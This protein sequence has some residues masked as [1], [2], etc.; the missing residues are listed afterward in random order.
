[1]TDQLRH[2][3]PVHCAEYNQRQRAAHNCFCRPD[4]RREEAPA[5]AL[6]ELVD[7]D[8]GAEPESLCDLAKACVNR[9]ARPTLA[10]GNKKLDAE[11]HAAEGQTS[12]ANPGW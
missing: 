11:E 8:S 4:I 5:A 7:V 9:L 6:A 3:I 2:V 10:V 1:M 12:L